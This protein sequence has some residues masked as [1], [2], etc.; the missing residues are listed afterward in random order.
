MSRLIKSSRKIIPIIIAVI[1]LFP[2]GAFASTTEEINTKPF[3]LTIE[4][5]NE[6]LQRKLS[7]YEITETDK[8]IDEPYIHNTAND[9]IFGYTDYVNHKVVIYN[10]GKGIKDNHT[11]DHEAGH[12][13]DTWDNENW[14]NSKEEVP[15]LYSHSDEFESIFEKE[16]HSIDSYSLEKYSNTNIEEY[17]AETFAWYLEKPK[18][19][20]KSSPLTY[21]FMDKVY[22]WKN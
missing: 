15:F 3:A 13:F 20:K 8:K 6:R 2:I 5:Y 17:F 21:A 9:I 22:N 10:T 4:N 16:R 19:L 12:V 7:K 14:S 18:Q 11:M 1:F